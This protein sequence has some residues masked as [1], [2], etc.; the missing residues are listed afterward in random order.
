MTIDQEKVNK[1]NTDLENA[2]Y[3]QPQLVKEILENVRPQLPRVLDQET[4]R[5]IE[6]I[7]ITGCGDSFFAGAATEL[8]FHQLAG[9]DTQPIEALNF[10]RYISPFVKP[11][12]LLISISNSGK[13]SRTIEATQRANPKIDTLAITDAPESALGKAAKRLL[14]PHIPYLPSGGAGTRSYMASLLCLYS[15]ALH[16]GKERGHLSPADFDQYSAMLYEIGD[17]VFQTLNISQ[18]PVQKYA[19]ALKTDRLFFVGGGP[20]HGTA[21]FG[22]AKVMEA[23]SLEGIAVELEEW[24]HLQFHTTMEQT[25]YVVIAPPGASYDRAIEQVKG[26][27]NSGGYVAAILDQKDSQISAIADYFFPVVSPEFEVFS[28]LIYCLPT[29][30][31][32]VY[33]AMTRNLGM[34]MR[35]DD[36]RK[37]VN[38]QQIFNSD[39]K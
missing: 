15:I 17:L 12:S 37:N 25:A 34:K 26:I 36:H 18:S 19:Q 22:A 23:L 28:P 39:I 7:Y 11:G 38:F 4:A 33:L 6:K 8:A 29:E 10:S 2:V 9:I 31:L 20:N 14:F 3:S 1:I 35:L 24:A 32:A 21:M 5:R 27:K 13:V 16:L 30:L